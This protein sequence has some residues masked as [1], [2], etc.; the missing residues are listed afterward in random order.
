MGR[1]FHALLVACATWFVSTNAHASEWQYV[2]LPEAKT[3][4]A[5]GPPSTGTQGITEI[6]SHAC[7]QNLAACAWLISVAIPCRSGEVSPSV[8]VLPKLVMPGTNNPLAPALR[9][10]GPNPS[11]PGTFVYK[12]EET[13]M[14]RELLGVNG[15][16]VI[17]VG[18][19][20]G[21]GMDVTLNF[22]GAA[23]LI[24]KNEA[25]LR[26]H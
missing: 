11:L 14:G 24:A 22:M 21:P 17:R 9:C 13:E 18:S 20:Q 15:P 23:P 10:G 16:V 19:Q 26:K 6:V 8:V 1:Q 12:F 4:L 5:F 3:H 2:F 25:G 7:Y